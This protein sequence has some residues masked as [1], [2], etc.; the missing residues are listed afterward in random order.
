MAVSQVDIASNL[1][2]DHEVLSK[3]LVASKRMIVLCFL[4]REY[5]EG[6]TYQEAEAGE[7]DESQDL[8]YRRHFFCV[9][10]I[11][12]RRDVFRN[13]FSAIGGV[14]TV[15]KGS[16]IYREHLLNACSLS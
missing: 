11:L 5:K 12:Q 14:N 13:N 6:D 10:H 7:L 2:F 15:N 9:C 1:I 4:T 16:C 8:A 3:L